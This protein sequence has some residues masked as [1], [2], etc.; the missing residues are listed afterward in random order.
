MYLTA[1]RPD[2][3]FAVCYCA[4]YQSNPRESHKIVVK[5]IFRYL[6]GTP[7]LGLWYPRNE[8]FEFIAYSDSDHGDCKLD[9]KSV[10][11]GCQYLGNRLVSWQCKKA[12]YCIYFY[13]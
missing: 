12:D 3:M 6:K 2:I 7:Q 4:R 13:R 11:G 10:T 1:S 8:D 9:R 5:R